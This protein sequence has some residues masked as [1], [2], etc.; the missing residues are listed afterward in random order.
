MSTS[1]PLRTESPPIYEIVFART[2]FVLESERHIAGDLTEAGLLVQLKKEVPLILP[3]PVKDFSTRL[4]GIVGASFEDSFWAV[5]PGG[6]AI[7]DALERK[8]QLAPEQ[9]AASR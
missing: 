3:Q 5:H 8:C 6:R 9:L 4:L 2:T 7:L 1:S